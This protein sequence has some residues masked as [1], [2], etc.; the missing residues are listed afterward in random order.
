LTDGSRF[1]PQDAGAGLHEPTRRSLAVPFRRLALLPGRLGWRWNLILLAATFLTTTLAGG[2][3]L[4]A[5][6]DPVLGSLLGPVLLLA[7]PA[8]L[9]RAGLPYSFSVIAI[10]GAHEMGHYLACR[11]YAVRSTPPF[12]I[13]FPMMFGTLGA[14]IRIRQAVPHRKALFDIGIA[15]PLAGFA[16]TLLVLV[17][18]LAT[19]EVA[20][21]EPGPIFAAPMALVLLAEVVGR[22]VPAGQ[23]LE[24][25][26]FLLAAWVGALATAINLFPSGQLDGGHICYAIS[27]GLHRFFS[28]LTL[29][30][31]CVLLVYTTLF[32]GSPVWLAWVVALWFMGHRHPV[33]VDETE[34][35]SFGR[36]L[37]AVVALAV[38]LLTFTPVPIVST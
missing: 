35:L 4:R 25:N 15:G 11:R 5:A 7:A 33:L 2:G 23:G 31:M 19:A 1:D 26:P 17:L 27:R 8:E 24:M 34:R 6:D 16:V 30:G 28:R 3:F 20:P 37:L 21:P 13:P 22:P 36:W 14:V 32:F 18:G 10:L 12:F 9:L 29:A 38:F